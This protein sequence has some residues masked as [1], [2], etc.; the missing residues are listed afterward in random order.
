MEIDKKEEDI[1][2]LN[3][4]GYFSS[5]ISECTTSFR[6]LVTRHRGKW[7][8]K[9]SIKHVTAWSYR[10]LVRETNVGT[11]LTFAPFAVSPMHRPSG[12]LDPR[13]Q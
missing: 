11:K 7:L 12:V 1:L 5:K 4:Q 13:S 10:V 2:I 3:T 8:H 9:V 6:R